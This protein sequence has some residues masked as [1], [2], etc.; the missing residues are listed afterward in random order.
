MQA[1]GSSRGSIHGREV[2]TVVSGNITLI[3]VKQIKYMGVTL[4]DREGSGEAVRARLNSTWNKKE[5][6]NGVIC[7]NKMEWKLKVNIYKTTTRLC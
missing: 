5:E 4:S 6:G 7:D 3:Q 2:A 1:R